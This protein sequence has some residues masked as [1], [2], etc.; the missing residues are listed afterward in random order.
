MSNDL[1]DLLKEINTTRAYNIF[2]P[3]LKSTIRFKPLIIEQFRDFIDKVANTPYFNIGFQQ[4]L[5][6]IIR[7]N[8]LTE[9]ISIDSFTEIDKLAIALSIRVN[10]ISSTYSDIDITSIKTSIEQ[11]SHLE[12]YSVT[13]DNITILCQVPTLKTEFN[14]NTYAERNLNEDVEDSSAL[15]DIIDLMFVAEIAK[16][17]YKI[18]VDGTE[19]LQVDD[20]AKWISAVSNLPISVLNEA[21]V[22]TDKVKTVKDELLKVNEN[23]TIDYDLRLFTAV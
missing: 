13:K 4:E 3:S 8:T 21:L 14:Y 10:D 2:V 19:Y 15:K 20:F 1:T 5:T 6:N 16:C 12:N 17:V 11:L 18:T 7:S 23:V 9:N 22:Y